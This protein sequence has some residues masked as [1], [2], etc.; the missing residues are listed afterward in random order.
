MMQ[1]RDG[2]LPKD[3]QDAA[4]RKAVRLDGPS[5][6]RLSKGRAPSDL[7][8]VAFRRHGPRPS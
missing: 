5:R 2:E 7:A 4:V 1:E 3:M 6:F 8:V